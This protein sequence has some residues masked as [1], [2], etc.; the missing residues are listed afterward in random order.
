MKK[1]SEFHVF[2]ND[3]CRSLKFHFGSVEKFKGVKVYRYRV[4]KMELEDP[5]I[6]T[7]NQC[8]CLSKTLEECP[9]AGTISLEG[10]RGGA[11]I[12]M[13][14]PYFL[15]GFDGYRDAAGLPE[16]KESEH[17]TYL[18]IEPTSGVLLRGHKRIQ[19]NVDLKIG[20]DIDAYAGLKNDIVFPLL[21]ADE[22]AEI[23]DDTVG[24]L[25][26]KLLTPK[27]IVDIAKWVLI[28]V[29]IALVVVGGFVFYKRRKSSTTV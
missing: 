4:P 9:H 2:S 11:P 27:K 12:M 28:G 3:L 20:Y 25:K 13:S 29:G 15:D 8:Y 17:M 5:R 23:D 26:S 16:P 6:N 7:E 22:S 19:V 21:W 1:E 10:C 24:D 14:T 18:D